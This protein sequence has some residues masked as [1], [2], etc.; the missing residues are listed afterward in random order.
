MP[1]YSQPAMVDMYREAKGEIE[2]LR[3]QVKELSETII[4]CGFGRAEKEIENLRQQNKS[5]LDYIEKQDLK[6]AQNVVDDRDEWKRRTAAEKLAN[7]VLVK[8]SEEWERRAMLTLT[9]ISNQ[10]PPGCSLH[11]DKYFLK[12]HPEAAKWFEAEG[13]QSSIEEKDN[14]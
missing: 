9:W 12:D 14:E 5:L 3:E 13:F 6:N 8:A 2:S 4:E 7:T 11:L 10:I 1:V